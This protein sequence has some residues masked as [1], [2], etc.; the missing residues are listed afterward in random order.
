[1]QNILKDNMIKSISDAILGVNCDTR[2]G[3]LILIDEEKDESLI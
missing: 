1:M 3:I 2:S